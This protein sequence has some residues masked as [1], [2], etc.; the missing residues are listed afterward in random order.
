MPL[1]KVLFVCLGNACRSQMAEG[2]ARAYGK[3][4]WGVHTAMGYYRAPTDGWT[5]ERL[6]IAYDLFFIGG[7]SI[8]SEPNI[9]FRNWGS[10][11]TRSHDAG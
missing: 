4:L 1:Q 9:A 11:S 2:F 6:R 7:A 3:D 10:C 8:F 5:P